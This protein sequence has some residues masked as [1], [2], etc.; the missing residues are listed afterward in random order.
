VRARAREIAR[1]TER[2]REI[3]GS[4]SGP[5]SLHVLESECVCEREIRRERE[6]ER[7][8]ER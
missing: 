2:E 1:E 6:R 3:V 7:E 8:I 5:Y 4:A